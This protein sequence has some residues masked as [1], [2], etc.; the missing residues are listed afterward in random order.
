MNDGVRIL[1]ER[2]KTNPEDFEHGGRFKW[3]AESVEAKTSRNGAGF[4]FLRS[5]DADALVNAWKEVMAEKFSRKV[6]TDLFDDGFEKRR[7]EEEIEIAKLQQQAYQH[8]LASQMAR[9]FH[10]QQGLQN[11]QGGY[12]AAQQANTG[13]LM[14]GL[15]GFFG[16]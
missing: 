14:A 15:S 5:E 12:N 13:G 11:T 9:T 7:M 2:M 4:W 3:V 10:G 6:M 1:I 8:Q 16:R